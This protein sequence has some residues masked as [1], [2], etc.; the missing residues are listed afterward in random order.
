MNGVKHMQIINCGYNYRHPN[1]FKIYRPNGS[2]DCILLIIH[3]PAFF[4][5]K[6]QKHYT[7]G[8]SV[9]VFREGTPQIYG[10]FN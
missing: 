5:F 3:S 6:N 4:V 8:N 10:A 1:D 7:A 2:G 9:V